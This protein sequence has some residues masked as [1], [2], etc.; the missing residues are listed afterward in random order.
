MLQKGFPL[1]KRYGYDFHFGDNAEALFK[2]EF[3]DKLAWVLTPTTDAIVEPA[4][5]FE[6]E[7]PNDP[8]SVAASTPILA[9]A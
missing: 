8:A 6:G 3:L 5:R 9:G 1:L 7:E 2:Y 4:I